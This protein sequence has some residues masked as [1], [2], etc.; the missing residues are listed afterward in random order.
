MLTF[1]SAAIMAIILSALALAGW[2]AGYAPL[3]I[4]F[5]PFLLL[6]L[7]MVWGASNIRSNFFMAATCKGQT[8]EKAVALT[9]DDGP[10]PEV[11]PR[12]L[13]ILRRE[14][15]QATFF[16]IGH[17][18]EQHASLIQQMKD[19]GHIIANHSFSHSKM[20]D[21]NLE[22]GWLQ[23]LRRTSELIKNTTGM[24]PLWFRPPYGVTT[25]HLASA[26][27]KEG[28][29]VIGWSI[30]TMDTTSASTSQI[31]ENR[32]G[33]LQNG[34]I[35]L[36]HDDRRRTPQLLEEILKKCRQSGFKIAELPRLINKQPYA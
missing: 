5:L 26:V 4:S 11:T 33:T 16:V 25:P 9:F 20:I 7:L 22:A 35:L 17:K 13:E 2:K 23:E 34:D 18:A 3:W 8:N 15:L 19:N 12:I 29:H 27:R 24:R 32:V 10:D 1:R 28:L 21:L 36:L 6:F 14:N 31:M 30:R